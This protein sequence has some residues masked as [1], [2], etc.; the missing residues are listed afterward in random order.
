MLTFF[1]MNLQA[2]NPP[3]QKGVSAADQAA[4]KAL[5]A[6]VDETKYALH[7]GGKT[8]AGKRAVG[9]TDLKQVKRVT[10]PAEAAGYIILIVEGDNVIYVLAVG[11]KNLT[12]VLGVEKTTKLN[13]I[14][15]K[16]QR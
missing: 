15:A 3:T 2:Q 11:K 16:Y 14:M 6:G 12:S 5:F 9:M 10:N 4:I 8:V 7:F 1:T 13:Q